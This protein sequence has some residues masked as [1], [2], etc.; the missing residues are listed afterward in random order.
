MK[1]LTKEEFIL[2]AIKVHGNDYGYSLV[3]YINNY[4]KVKIIC[5]TCRYIFEQIP[6]NHLRDHGC[7]VCN[8]RNEKRNEKAK[9]EFIPKAIKV[10]GNDY[11]YSL[12]DYI[13]SNIK[14]KIICNICRYIFEQI[15][16]SHLRGH[17]CPVCTSS[18]GEKIARKFLRLNLITAL[19]QYFFDD[20]RSDFGNTLPY[21]FYLPEYNTLIEIDGLQHKS[22]DAAIDLFMGKRKANEEEAKRLYQTLKYHDSLKDQYAKEHNIPLYRIDAEDLDTVEQTLKDILISAGILNPAHHHIKTSS[23]YHIDEHNQILKLSA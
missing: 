18:L 15:P 17:G 19:P 11:G 3:D 8:Q 23:E 5:N 4:T 7:P 1:K 20:L 22:E 12:V 9:E 6:N 13:K 16:N 14:V 2:K 10:H 21:D